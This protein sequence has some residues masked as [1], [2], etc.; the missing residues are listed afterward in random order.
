MEYKEE[1]QVLTINR[2]INSF[3]GVYKKPIESLYPIY[4]DIDVYYDPKNPKLSYVLRYCNK[5]LLFYL[6]FC[7]A[8]LILM[9]DLLILLVL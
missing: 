4:S 8:L 2:T 3:V 1:N 9:V 5:K 6:T 7:S